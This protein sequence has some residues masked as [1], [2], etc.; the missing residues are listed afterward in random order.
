MRYIMRRENNK[1]KKQLGEERKGNNKEEDNEL[2]YKRRRGSL[3]VIIRV[4]REQRRGTRIER[5]LITD[6][7]E[8]NRINNK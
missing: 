6:K 7:L 8:N 3:S 5:I 4:E 1:K 2:N